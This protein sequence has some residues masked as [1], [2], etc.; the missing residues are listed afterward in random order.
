M[1]SKSGSRHLLRTIM[2]IMAIVLCF[3]AT[4]AFFGCSTGG[5][6]TPTY[7]YQPPEETP[8]VHSVSISY[9]DEAVQGV[10]SVDVT[11]GEIQLGADVQKD[12][13]AQGTLAFTSSVP[14]VATVDET[15]KV[16]LVSAGETVITA[17]FGGVKSNM[18]LVVSSGTTGRYTV[19]VAGG[20][21]D[22]TTASAGDIITLTPKIPAHQEFVE[23]SFAGSEAEV[24]WI[25]GNMFKMPAGNVTVSATF[26]DMLYT[27][28][29]VGAK[30]TDDGNETVQKGTVI[31]YDGD[32]RSPEFAMT[33]YKY[34][35]GT[36]LDFEAVDPSGNYMFVGWD[37]NTVNNRIDAEEEITGFVMPDEAT[38]YW[39]NFSPYTTKKL[40]QP[41]SIKGN[42]NPIEIDGTSPTADPVLEGLSG[43]TFNIPAGTLASTSYNEHIEGSVL[44]TVTQPSQAI[45]A[46][47][48]NRGLQPVTV[49]IYATYLTNIATSGWITV[50]P[51][52]TVSKTFIALLGFKSRPWW[53]FSVR[54]GTTVEGGDV[55][56]DIVVGCADAYPKGDKTLSV[57]SGTRLVQLDAYKATLSDG[58]STTV[59]NSQGWTLT[60]SYEHEHNNDVNPPAVMT[61]RL[62]NLPAYDP[63]D[64]YITLYIRMQNQSASDH[65][66]DYTFAFG[67]DAV[68]LDENMQLK[69]GTKAVDFTVYNHG[70]TKLFAIRLPREAEDQFYFS[71]IKL[72]YDTPDNTKP[73][74]MQ[75]YYAINFSVVL[76]YNN[77]IGFT[78]E[79]IE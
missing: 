12:D 38:T 8:K 14:E 77:G 3:A 31:G 58:F 49:E 64:P 41:N 70:E 22:I 20:S 63:A 32:T 60:A 74:R 53:G 23:W 5:G 51:G 50:Q 68:P 11:R 59:D 13:G 2:L 65:S 71:I 48:R 4:A 30:V 45:R 67:K 17:D 47:F 44:D 15:G 66:Y 72:K 21:A 43:Y 33:E 1:N 75:P 25:S 29:L 19:T 55:P 76:T 27:L 56:L 39:A 9:N 62:N 79:V 54:E 78:G 24:T 69:D 34:A 10:L 7:T 35:Y 16:T 37:A 26:T 61:A 57:S 6:T 73:D 18:V 42:W 36:E 40:L 46:I 52:E 28:T